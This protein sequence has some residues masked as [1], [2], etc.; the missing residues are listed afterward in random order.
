MFGQWTPSKRLRHVPALLRGRAD[1]LSNPFPHPGAGDVNGSVTGILGRRGARPLQ[2]PHVVNRLPEGSPDPTAAVVICAHSEVRW[3][4]LVAAVESVKQQTYRPAEIVLV[5]DH[6]PTLQRRSANE[7]PGVTVVPNDNEEGLPGA[8]NAGAAAASSEIVAFIDDDAVADRN[9][10]AALVAPY[11]DPHVLGVGGQVVPIWQ[12]RRPNW[13]PAEFDWV[14]GCS[15]HGMPA[16]RTRV[17]NFSGASVSLRR[18]PLVESGG[19]DET[20]ICARLQRRYLDGVYLYEPKALVR[21]HVPCSRSTWSYYRSRCYT[22]GLSKA[23]VRD[24]AGPE[25]TMSSEKSSLRS[26]IPRA[27]G[28]NLVKA[29]RGEPSG[30]AGVMALTGGVFINGIGYTVGRI[31]LP[32]NTKSTQARWPTMTELGAI[33]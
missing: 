6:N 12:T 30:L 25:W 18:R 5:I 21:R 10:L 28:R 20:E 19:F 3:D 11:A 33:G 4:D 8:R 15:Y 16:E 14:V 1:L 9:W 32:G 31:R 2:L 29:L 17:R 13:F 22:E 7:L 23:A 26:I 27:I 24:L